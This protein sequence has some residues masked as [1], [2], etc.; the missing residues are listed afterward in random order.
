MLEDFCLNDKHKIKE[1]QDAFDLYQFKDLIKDQQKILK[2]R[3]Y[4]KEDL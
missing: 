3:P 1:F 4:F 2:T